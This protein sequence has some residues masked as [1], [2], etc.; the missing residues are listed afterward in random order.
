MIVRSIAASGLVV[1]VRLG[2]GSGISAFSSP[3]RR[4]GFYDQASSASMRRLPSGG[5][6]RPET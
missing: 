4:R 2:S 3:D 6:Y 5:A 1:G